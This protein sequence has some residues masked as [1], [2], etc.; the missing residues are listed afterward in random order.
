MRKLVEVL[1]VT[2]SVAVKRIALQVKMPVVLKGHQAD[3][4]LKMS[5]AEPPDGAS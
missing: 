4:L 3:E 2:I 1:E 5:L